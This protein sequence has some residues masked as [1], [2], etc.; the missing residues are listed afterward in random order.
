MIM[1]DARAL[2]AT[3]RESA[4]YTEYA[5][6]R[7]KAMQSESTRALYGEYRRVQ[8]RA[9]ADAVSGRRD[10]KTLERLKT[11]GELLQFDTDAAAFL[12]AEYR[13]TDLLGQIYRVLAEAAE[14]D[15]GIP[16]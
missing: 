11:L 5:A 15:L 8:M 9:Q 12:L 16:D 4:E 14:V 6:A 2:A 13:L 10:E 1:D 3:L 7:E